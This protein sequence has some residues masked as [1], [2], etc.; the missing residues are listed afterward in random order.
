MKIHKIAGI[1]MTVAVIFIGNSQEKKIN[2]EV[3]FNY[4]VEQFADI[5]V[6]RYQIPGWQNLTLKEQKL[7]YYLTQASLSGRDIMWDQNYKYNLKIRKAL[8]HIYQNYKGDKTS[9][10]WKKFEIYLKRVWFSNGIH[11]HYSTDKIKPGFSESYFN[12]LMKSTKTNLSP[13]I[14]AIIFNEVDTKKVNLEE[15]KGLLEGSAINFYDKGI[16]LKETENFYAKK[17]SPDPKKPYSFGLNSK[18]VRNSKGQLEEKG[19]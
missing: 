6:L 7:V 10:D 9:E 8:E 19:G 13:T 12:S 17:T 5:K 11:H 18:L 15:S 1:F 2:K 16:S 4:V 14:A 3:P